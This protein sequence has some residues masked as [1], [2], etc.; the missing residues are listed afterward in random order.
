MKLGLI[1]KDRVRV[2]DGLGVDDKL[3]VSGHRLVGHGDTV[4]VL[5]ER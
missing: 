4:T 1:K 2:L 3:I 5:G